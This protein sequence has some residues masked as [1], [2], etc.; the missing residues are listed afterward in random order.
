MPFPVKIKPEQNCGT[1]DMI[2]QQSNIQCCGMNEPQSPSINSYNPQQQQQ[3]QQQ[4]QG[5]PRPLLSPDFNNNMSDAYLQV[6]AGQKNLGLNMG[7]M[8]AQ[9]QAFQFRIPGPM[10]TVGKS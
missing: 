8:H 7:N 6:M 3:Q 10:P 5:Q 2:G 9:T 1:Y 4:Q